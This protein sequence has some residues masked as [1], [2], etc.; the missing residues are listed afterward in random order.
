M[1]LVVYDG[2]QGIALE[3]MQGNQAKSRVDLGYP[4]LFH[5]PLLISMFLLTCEGFLRDSL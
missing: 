1:T 2:E 5:I 4:E 3:K